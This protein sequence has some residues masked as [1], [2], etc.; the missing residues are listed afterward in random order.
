VQLLGEM[1]ELEVEDGALMYLVIRLC[2][3]NRFDMALELVETANN[4][5]LSAFTNHV[6]LHRFRPAEEATIMVSGSENS[7][8][9]LDDTTPASERGG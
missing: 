7:P 2:F 9:T 3:P 4:T 1:W 8:L 5:A 6:K